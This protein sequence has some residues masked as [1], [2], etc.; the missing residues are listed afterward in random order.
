VILIL[1]L[2]F[3]SEHATAP[4]GLE[5]C[6]RRPDAQFVDLGSRLHLQAEAC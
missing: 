6:G 1:A 3:Q 5:G 4:L 2:T